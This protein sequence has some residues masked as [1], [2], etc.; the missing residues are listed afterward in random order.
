VCFR[1]FS[2]SFWLIGEELWELEDDESEKSAGKTWWEDGENVV[3]T[4]L[5]GVVSQKF[6]S[7]LGVRNGHRVEPVRTS[8]GSFDCVWRQKPRQTPLRMT[9]QNYPKNFRD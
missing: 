4:W 2:A 7:K 6:L 3:R 9:I 8:S 1:L 5:L